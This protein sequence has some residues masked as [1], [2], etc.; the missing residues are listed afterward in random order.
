[1][2]SDVCES[3]PIATVLVHIKGTATR[4][5][6]G[7]PITLQAAPARLRLHRVAI[8]RDEAETIVRATG[9]LRTAIMHDGRQRT[10]TTSAR[11]GPVPIQLTCLQVTLVQTG[12]VLCFLRAVK[13]GVQIPTPH[14]GQ[15]YLQ[16]CSLLVH[17][18]CQ[19]V[20]LSLCA[21]NDKTEPANAYK[22]SLATCLKFSL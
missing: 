14:S 6:R 2:S 19:A 7:L 3:L 10:L 1:M 22:L 5:C 4:T 9:S 12:D 15:A 11:R 21:P 17:C 20:C 16:C 13:E 8:E 18:H